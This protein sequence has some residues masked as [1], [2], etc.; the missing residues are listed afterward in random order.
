MSD[1]VKLAYLVTHPIQYQVPL[2]RKIAEEPDIDLTVFFCSD[3]S[4]K[5][6]TDPGFGRVVEWDV[7]LLEGYKYEFLP[8][9]GGTD[10]VSFWRP[11]NYGLAKRLKKGRFDVIW[12]H[13]YARWFHWIA[14]VIAKRLGIKVLIRDEANPISTR[15]GLLKRMTKQIFFR[16]L[17]IVCN[18]FLAI[19]TL[20]R[21]YYYQNGIEKERI[22]L[23]PY[24]VDNSFFQSKAVA[25]AVTRAELQSSLGL[26]LGR[27]IILY[28]S[29]LIERKRPADLLEAYARLSPDGQV[30]PNP[31]LL[32]IGDGDMRPSLEMRASELGWSSIRFLGFINQTELPRYYDLCDVFVL[33]S[34]NEPWG[35]VINEVMN[36]G[37][38]IIVSDQVGCAPDLVRSGENGYVFKAGDIDDLATCLNKVLFDN[39]LR[40]RMGLESL[41]HIEEWSFKQDIMGLRKALASIVY[42]GYK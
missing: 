12:I 16:G 9:V 25:S 41:L 37:R 20:N 3:F 33:P 21:D 29:K 32:I 5:G 42:E 13:G 31:Y 7:P 8:A 6:F 2:L 10:R 19:G 4:V 39:S 15:R 26:E 28:A 35:L 18:G 1:K 17:K 11:F 24:A 14:M 40:T 38:T 27:P 23:V 22:F 36:I 30:E 34:E